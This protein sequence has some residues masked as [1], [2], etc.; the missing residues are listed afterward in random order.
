MQGA[1]QAWVASHSQKQKA[2][3]VSAMSASTLEASSMIGAAAS[4]SMGSQRLATSWA[5]LP[6]HWTCRVGV[7]AEMVRGGQQTL[8]ARAR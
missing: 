3:R 4:R 7:H 8:Q 6:S 1:G 5:V 2:D